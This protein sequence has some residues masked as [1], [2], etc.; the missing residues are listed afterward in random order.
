MPA[1]PRLISTLL[2]SLA[3]TAPAFAVEP[4]AAAKAEVSTLLTRLAA[5]GC[6]FQRNGSWYNAAE[7]RAHLEKKYQYLLDKQRL[8]SA[9]DF[10]EM[11]A[12]RS[13]TSGKPYIVKCG[14]KEQPSAQWM[15]E[16]LKALRAPAAARRN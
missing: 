8:A 10:V 4:G 12:T 13:S 16:Q 5:S 14:D 3:V 15:G 6:T 1:F 11:A 2:I 9:E 7:A